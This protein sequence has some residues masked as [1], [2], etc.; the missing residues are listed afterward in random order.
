MKKLHI[1]KSGKRTAMNGST[2]EY[3]EDMLQACAA[4]YDPKVHEAP[5]VIG[6]PRD[7]GPAW[8]W[9]NSL[10]ADRNGLRAAP[11]QVDPT[12]AEMVDAGRFKKISASFYLPDSPANPKPG[13]LYLRHV[14][15]LG[16]QPPALKGLDPVSF[17]EDE[18][19]IVEFADM[20]WAVSSTSRLFSGIRDF[21]IEKFGLDAAD[22]VLP[23]W[24][25]DSLNDAV[26]SPEPVSASFS[27]S[28]PASVGSDQKPLPQENDVD[29]E[30]QERIERENAELKRQLAAR[31]ADDSKKRSDD[32]HAANVAFAEKLVTEARLAPRATSVVVAL[33]DAVDD[34]NAPVEFS[35]GTTTQPLSEAFK[36]LLSTG[37]PVVDFGEFASKDRAGG[38]DHPATTDD[39]FANFAESE[40]DADRLAIHRRATALA[41]KEN[42]SYDAALSRCI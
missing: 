15:F 12:F 1:F 7:N 30:T 18:E 42:I 16:A 21:F 25:I 38:K 26:R 4:A 24:Q 29:K 36:S 27:E 10:T 39:G 32:R 3:S 19:G 20:D 28:D 40:L 9:V 23:S 11:A 17:G 34:G 41:S 5:I 35:E 6:H 22:K 8:G 2:L 13:V 14:G 37:V 31:D 33:L